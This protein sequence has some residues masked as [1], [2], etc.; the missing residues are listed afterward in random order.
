V[1]ATRPTI[2]RGTN[3]AWANRGDRPVRMVFVMIRCHITNEL[4]QASGPPEFLDEV[5]E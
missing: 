3:L 1:S 4:K 5:L 2:Q